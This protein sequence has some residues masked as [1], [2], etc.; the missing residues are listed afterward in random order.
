MVL[1]GK[2][3]A[4][5]S[6]IVVIPKTTNV[7]V[8]IAVTRS[9]VPKRMTA[10]PAK[11]ALMSVQ[12]QSILQW[13]RGVHQRFVSIVLDTMDN[14]ILIM[15]TWVVAS[16]VVQPAIQKHVERLMEKR[17]AFVVRLKQYHAM[18]E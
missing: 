1:Q 4:A 17:L 2:K 7:A 13:N 12:N 3:N 16:V 5:E 8:V 18:K 9:V 6:S 15:C 14:Y 10:V 11:T